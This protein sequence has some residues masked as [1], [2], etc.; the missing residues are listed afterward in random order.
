M[1]RS[2]LAVFVFVCHSLSHCFFPISLMVLIR[3]DFSGLCLYGQLMDGCDAVF[4][5][6][7]SAHLF[8]SISACPGIHTILMR[9]SG[10]LSLIS[11]IQSRISLVI[12]YPDCLCGLIIAFMAVGC[13]YR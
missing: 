12:A 13:L 4:F 3:A 9:R 11:S 7:L 2:A 5:A 8:P 6:S 1:R 10:C